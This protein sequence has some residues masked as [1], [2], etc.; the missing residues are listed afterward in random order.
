MGAGIGV[1]IPP[2]IISAGHLE[3]ADLSFEVTKQGVLIKPKK[4]ETQLLNA[5]T[6]KTLQDADQGRHL[7]SYSDVESLC[8]A[9][10]I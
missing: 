7:A 10:Q 1:Q 8:N 5:I 6:E 9:L 2:H 3:N 4:Q